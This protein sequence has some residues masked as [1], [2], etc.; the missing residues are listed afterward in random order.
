MAFEGYLNH[1]IKCQ[2]IYIY[3]VMICE[4]FCTIWF[5]TKS[6][7]LCDHKKVF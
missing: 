3:I 1:K 5:N 6:T 4:A 7:D 2:P